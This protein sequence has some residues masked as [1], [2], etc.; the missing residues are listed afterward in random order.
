M[1]AKKENLRLVVTDNFWEM[2]KKVDSH[3]KLMRGKNPEDTYLIPVDLVRFASGEG[4]AVLQESVRDKDV[5]LLTDIM[6]YSGTYKMRGLVNHKSPDDNFMDLVRT[7][8]A[9]DG[10]EASLKVIMPFLYE[11]RQH[12]KRGRESK[13]CSQMLHILEFLGIDSII[14]FD[15]HDPSM[16]NALNGCPFD[17]LYPTESILSE[18]FKNE[19][20]LNNLIIIAPDGGAVE[21]ASFYADILGAE[22]GWYDKKRNRD[23]VVDGTNPIKSHRYIGDDVTGKNVIVVDDMIASGQSML[24]VAK[25]MTERGAK[26]VYLIASYA[27]F[28]DGKKNLD[29]YNEAHEK[30][31]FK[32]CYASN[33]TYVPEE[34]K[35]TEWFR[36]GDSSKDVAELIDRLNRHESISPLLDSKSRVLQKVNSLRTN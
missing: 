18:F 12:K 14:T 2:G 27:L 17:N 30:G 24:D 1:E 3:L 9:M 6:N 25:D 32:R 22:I 36:T 21:R 10:A 35:E 29:A 13:D 7:I 15:A 26:N 8:S 11:G 20:N 19:G 23:K 5:Y 28:S 34:L 16:T 31:Y 4:K 33:L